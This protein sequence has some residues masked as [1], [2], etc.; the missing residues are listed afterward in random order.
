[1]NSEMFFFSFQAGN[2]QNPFTQLFSTLCLS[3]C[4]KRGEMSM[5]SGRES[6]YSNYVKEIMVNLSIFV[7]GNS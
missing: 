6:F 5:K 2:E 1:M 7:M 4:K 3:S